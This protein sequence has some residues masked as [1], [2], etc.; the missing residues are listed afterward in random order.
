M[1]ILDRYIGTVL[2]R[3]FAY[4]LA[5]LLA[6]F[7]VINLTEELRLADTPAYGV[8]HVVSFILKTL[9]AE[10][11]RLFPAAALLGTVLGLGQLQSQNEIVALQAAGVSLGRLILTV[12]V[13]AA[14]LGTLGVAFGE[15]V[16]APLSLQAHRQ[17]ALALSGFRSLG[18]GPG[19]WVRDG[20]RF[21]NV[22]LVHPG[23]SLENVYQFDF[24]AGE[25]RRVTYAGGA[26]LRDGRWVLDDVHESVLGESGVSARQ[27][28]AQPWDPGVD[29]R[30]LQSLWLRPED[31]SIAE[32]H[33]T[34]EALR[35][36]R[37]N[38]LSYELAFWQALS[39]PL[40]A[41]VMVLLAVPIVVVVGRSVRVG[42]RI[43]VGALVGLGFQLFQQTF[44]NVGLVSGLPPALTALTP[45]ALALVAVTLLLR[46][47]MTQ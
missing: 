28:A 13:T 34:I 37:Q 40:Y 15:T 47:R 20:S 32:L 44:T 14:L 12:V 25:L 29:P 19:L 6:V 38:P 8:T 26:E 11:Y 31:L 4:A 27:I 7:S 42:E 41:I 45:A 39:A 18:T 36:Q 3:Q 9:P 10:A 22:G 16:A 46:R 17:R 5:A 43:V 21:V 33:R 1:L 23:G 30:Q 35:R 24:D 2:L